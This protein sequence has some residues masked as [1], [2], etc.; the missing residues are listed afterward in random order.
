MM[1]IYLPIQREEVIKNDNRFSK[2]NY[3][4]RQNY[5]IKSAILEKRLIFDNSLLTTKQT[6]YNL[7]DL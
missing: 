2:A 4:S 5:L 1:R 3:R 6:I 7:T